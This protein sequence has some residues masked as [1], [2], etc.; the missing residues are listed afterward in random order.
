MTRSK[1]QSG[2]VFLVEIHDCVIGLQDRSREGVRGVFTTKDNGLG[3]GLAVCPSIIE[4]HSGRRWTA[5][6]EGMS[7]YG[8]HAAS[9]AHQPQTQPRA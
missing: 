4:A 1:R 9:G 7:K 6:G 8:R 5:S 3:M 2:E